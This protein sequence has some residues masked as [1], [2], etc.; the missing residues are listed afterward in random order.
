MSKYFHSFRSSCLVAALLLTLSV[1]ALG[2]AHAPISYARNTFT[3]RVNKN[4]PPY[5]KYPHLGRNHFTRTP[6][7]S[8]GGR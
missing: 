1:V 4:G 5:T 3:P 7:K 2:C 6:P 8:N